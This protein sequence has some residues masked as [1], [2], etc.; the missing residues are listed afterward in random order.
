MRSLVFVTLWMLLTFHPTTVTNLRNSIDS[1]KF[2]VVPAPALFIGSKT[3]IIG[4]PEFT[5]SIIEIWKDKG[6][7][8]TYNCFE[9]SDHIM[10]FKTYPQEYLKLVEDHWKK[11][12]LLERK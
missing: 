2:Q 5:R 7:D 1:F 6:V 10:H 8:V 4:I 9:K 12:K 3:D 11:V